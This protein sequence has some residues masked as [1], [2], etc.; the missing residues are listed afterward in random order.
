MRLQLVEKARFGGRGG[1]VLALYAWRLRRCV[2]LG[3]GLFGI[4]PLLW[5]HVSVVTT[6][7]EMPSYIL[8][9]SPNLVT[10]LARSAL[11]LSRL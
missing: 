8:R 7:K 5:N 9:S 1:R 10:K 3:V 6:M 4:V 11:S 2:W